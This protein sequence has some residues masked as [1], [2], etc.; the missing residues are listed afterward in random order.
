MNKKNKKSV[1]V[2]GAG[3]F[4]GSH[5]VDR[6]AA[7]GYKVKAFVHYNSRN[8]WGWLES[9]MYKDEIEVIS[10]DI[11]DAD[12]VRLAMHKVDTVFHLA[13]L[14]GIP[15]SYY[16]PEAYVE[17]NIKGTL[18]VLQA[19]KDLG[20]S[21]I[22][23]TSTSEVYGS[24]QFV[25]ITEAHPVN[26]QSP[27][28]ATKS[29]ADFI[30]L[31]FYRSFDLPVAVVRPFNVYGP[32][33]SARAII[34]TIITQILSGRKKIK[35]GALSPTRDLTYVED[36]VEGFICCMKSS[37]AIGEVINLGS[38][39]E[40]S[41]K[42]LVG[43]I[44][45]YLGSSAKIESELQRKRPQKSEVKRLLADNSK[46]KRIFKWTPKYTL[47]KGLHK[48]IEWFKKNRNIYKDG[49]YNI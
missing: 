15:Y 7:L 26:P 21:R 17:T 25:P 47:E 37:A 46:A 32:R 44:T 31:S 9:S 19:A 5:L 24:A 6:L 42:E 36:T 33:Q 48:T 18:N 4:I 10:G 14:I 34:P 40:I 43:L 22:I 41:I 38:N 29:A 1:M 16:S 28:A 27:Y 35:L 20:V 49:I 12:I 8:S 11:R 45:K 23:H 13:A 39:S 3:G 30:A 2:T